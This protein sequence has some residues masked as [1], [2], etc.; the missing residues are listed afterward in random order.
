MQT[1][2]TYIKCL[3][4]LLAIC[5][6]P[7]VLL[8]KNGR[9]AVLSACCVYQAQTISGTVTDE[10]G[11]PLPGVN[12]LIKGTT[13]G[14]ASDLEGKY[15]IEAKPG[16]VLVFSFVGYAPKEVEVGA[17][18]VIDVM[19]D[20]TDE[21]L[22]EVVLIGYGTATKKSV[23]TAISNVANVSSIRSRPVSTLTDFLQGNVAGVTV[24]Q[25]GGDPTNEGRVVIRGYGSVNVDNPLTVVDGVPY[26]GPPINP[27]DIVSV[28]VLKDAAASAIYGAQAGN[29]VIVIETRKGKIGKPVVT[30]DFN[31]GFSNATNLPTALTAKEQAQVYN[32][33]A[34]NAGKDGKKQPAHDAT[35]NPWGQTN[36]TDWVKEIFRT[37]KFT[38]FNAGLSGA[39]EKVNYMASFGYNKKEG[40][41]IGTKSDRYAFRVKSEYAL[42]DRLTV[43][44]NVYFSRTEAVGTNT[45]SG[46]SGTIIN[47]IYMPSA[48]PVRDEKGEFHGVAP[49]DLKQFAGAYGDVYNPVALL[50]RPNIKSPTNFLTANIFGTYEIIPGLSVK[51]SYVYNLKNKHYKRF[52]PRVPELGR[53]NKQNYL[54]EENAATNGWTW[55]NQITYKRIFGLHDFEV[56]AIYSAQKTSHTRSGL[57]G[58]GFSNESPALQYMANASEVK[59]PQSE[60]WKDALISAIGRVMYNYDGRY[61]LSASLRR[62][63]S[64]RLAAGNRSEVFPAISAAWNIGNEPF[65]DVPAVSSLK[66]RASYGEIGNISPVSYY[67]FTAPMSNTTVNIGKDG[68]VNDRGQYLGRVANQKLK[69]ERSKSQNIGLDVGFL[70]DQLSFTFDYFKKTTQGMLIR[71]LE[72]HHQGT[73]AGYVNG[74]EVENSGIELS[75]GY[76]GKIGPL[77]FKANANA[78]FLKNELKNLN[79]YN[80]VGI[81]YIP[82]SDEVRGV[83]N[84][85]RSEIGQPIFAYHLVPHLGV[86]QTKAEIDAHTTTVEGKKVK[87]QPNAVPG[88]FKFQDTNKDGKIDDKDRVF[89]GSYL[90]KVTYNL[91]FNFDYK[92]FDLGLIFQGVGGVKV[93][94][95]YKF[96]TYNAALQGYNLD[97]RVLDAWSEKNTGANI[98][99]ISTKDNNHNFSN[100]S[101]W[102]LEN[103]NYLRLKNL[104]LGYTLSNEVVP[105][106]D[107]KNLR[108]YMSVENLFTIT[109]YTGMDPE[110]GGK[111]M[112]VGA[113]PLSRTFS[114]G[115]SLTL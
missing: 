2:Q 35:Q 66:L 95:A 86:F 4:W 107:T 58:L 104:S 45:S 17:Q 18:A 59:D 30:L 85:F 113:Y 36:R 47:A 76:K 20:E 84:P 80:E 14:T 27:S 82:H 8:A 1:K 97:K 100:T 37:A 34:E 48:A 41:L 56:T 49:Y 6:S 94:N 3:I 22:D 71:G 96:T 63:V 79:G 102:Y 12:V 78:S 69:W 28:S 108:V 83:L 72:D 75:L 24:L 25:Q 106:L 46:Y 50:L 43:G 16:D 67:S 91:G 103:G 62:D 38:N 112:D 88:D 109:K 77:G 65:F 114:F 52:N 51:S 13:Q 23:T 7:A 99:R 93:F 26:Y 73:S 105:F 92:G 21:M 15:T 9:S 81:N 115:L 68:K 60:A 64:S 31:K 42:T 11:E 87:I 32:L 33:A 44:E 10:L 74:G 39:S 90:P 29:G 53:T 5:V 54:Y 98:P 111:G 19:M 110:V 101:S 55:D 40:V 61:F 89:M 70:R 57:L